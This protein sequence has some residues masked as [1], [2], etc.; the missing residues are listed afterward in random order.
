MIRGGLLTFQGERS[1]PDQARPGAG[2][3][4]VTRGGTRR[5]PQPAVHAV[6]SVGVVGSA[7]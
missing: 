5:G 3:T 2:V 6:T 1:S 7:V 4:Q